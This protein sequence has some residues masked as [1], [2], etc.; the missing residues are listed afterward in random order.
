[1]ELLTIQQWLQWLH[2]KVML[3]GNT[4]WIKFVIAALWLGELAVMKF[5]ESGSWWFLGSW[6]METVVVSDCRGAHF[7]LYQHREI[8]LQLCYPFTSETS[9][10]NIHDTNLIYSIKKKTSRSWGALTSF[11]APHGYKLFF[12]ISHS[13]THHFGFGL[14]RIDRIDQSLIT[15][16]FH[17]SAM[18]SAVFGSLLPLINCRRFAAKTC[19]YLQ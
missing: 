19:K 2:Y 18:L 14:L 8:I 7:K 15:I 17:S 1:M 4:W 6:A 12:W 10:L 16:I 9:L 3:E 5:L 11:N 13:Q